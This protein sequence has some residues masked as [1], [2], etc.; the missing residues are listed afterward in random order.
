MISAPQV[1]AGTILCR[2]ARFG[3]WRSGCARPA[4]RSPPPAR[5]ER[6]AATRTYP[7]MPRGTHLACKPGRLGD[8]PE[9]PPHIVIIQRCPHSRR[10]H[11]PTVLATA[12][13]LQAGPP[14][15]AARCS[16]SAS[17]RARRGNASVRRDS[18]VLVSPASPIGPPHERRGPARDQ[19]SASPHRLP[20]ARPA[21]PRHDPSRSAQGT[22]SLRTARQQRQGD[23]GLQ[24]GASSRS[25]QRDRLL[26]RR[27]TPTAARHPC[28]LRRASTS[29]ATLR[30][31]R[32]S[33]S[34]C[35]IARTST[36][37][38]ICIV[39]DDNRAASA[40]SAPCTSP[41]VRS[42]SLTV[43]SSSFE[44]P[45]TIVSAVQRHR[46]APTGHPRQRASQSSSAS[47]TV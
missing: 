39:R 24:P 2:Y 7:S 27:T 46:P 41:A 32:S 8:H 11:Q 36:L 14:P 3:R 28:P 29:A 21:R 5:H 35:R 26:P 31:T 12:T 10:E 42:V 25:H 20:L 15:A 23:I 37:C 44:A 47:P 18:G 40:A 45:C 38:A 30:P 33:R 9:L 17:T 13:P 43:P 22:T 6:T 1:R 19:T 34:A 4:A 16:R